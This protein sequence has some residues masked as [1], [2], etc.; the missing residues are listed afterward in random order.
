MSEPSLHKEAPTVAVV[1]GRPTLNTDTTG[2]AT[3]SP[4]GA[5]VI[6]PALVPYVLA[7]VCVADIVREELSNPAPWNA[8]R[9]IGLGIRVVTYC[10]L[11]ASPG[12]RRTGYPSPSVP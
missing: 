10:A 11:G 7:G 9:V 3:V 5:P 4:T 2:V 6:P 1:D 8:P 12:W